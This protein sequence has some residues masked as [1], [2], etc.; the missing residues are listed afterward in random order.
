MRVSPVAALRDAVIDDAARALQ[1][2]GVESAHHDAEALAAHALGVDRSNLAKAGVFSG[3]QFELFRT[4]ILRRA[5][6][7]PLQYILGTAT[8]R[9]VDVLVGPGAFVPRPETEVV[10]GWVIDRYLRH[11]APVIVDLCAGP[12]TMALALAQEMPNARVHAVEVD[13]A[14]ADWA[15]RNIEATGL[16]VTLHVTD[17]AD[18]LTDLDASVDVVAANPPYL[19]RGTVDQPEVVDHEPEIAL[20]A[21]DGGVA[22]IRQV[23]ATAHRLLRPGGT[24]VVEHGDTQGSVVPALLR[25][26]GFTEVHDHQDLTGRDRFTTGVRA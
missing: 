13:V 14:A 24:L 26:Q 18:C 4:L 25:E 9:R 17:V 19:V 8:F 20:Y 15:K 7:E 12:G 23:V 10:A 21:G 6:R 3:A 16:D 2:A 1:D 22:V 5:K 11:G